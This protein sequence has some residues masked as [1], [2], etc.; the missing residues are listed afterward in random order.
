[1][2]RESGYN[3]RR[4]LH[5]R[6]YPYASW[7]SR[8]TYESSLREIALVLDVSKK[9]GGF[10]GEKSKLSVLKDNQAFSNIKSSNVRQYI[11]ESV[12]YEEDIP[13][14]VIV[15]TL[16]EGFS[17]DENSRKLSGYLN[18]AMV[19]N[20]ET[21][22]YDFVC[23]PFTISYG[24]SKNGIYTFNKATLN[25]KD[26]FNNNIRQAEVNDMTATVN[27]DLYPTISIEVHDGIEK[28]I[29]H[30]CNW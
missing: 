25:Y 17:F 13:N 2:T 10:Y 8:K 1:M 30:L 26:P 15:K 21:G 20:V 29:L 14:D 22:K 27:G 12:H 28:L 5:R 19:K 3:C 6:S 7:N 23:E 24:F 11:F 4:R 18:A 16:P 9:Y